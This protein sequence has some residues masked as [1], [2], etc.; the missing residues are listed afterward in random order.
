MAEPETVNTAWFHGRMAD[1][2]LSQRGLARQIGLDPGA[3]SLT[4]RGKRTMRMHEAIDLARLLGVPLA[5]L[6]V[7]SGIRQQMPSADI[8][9]TGWLDQ[10]GEVHFEPELG[11]I[12]RPHGLPS[13][14]TAVQCRTAGSDL[15]YMDGWLLFVDRPAEPPTADHLGRLCLVRMSGSVVYLAQ[16]RRGYTAGRWNLA[17]P[18]AHANDVAVDW[19]A[20]ILTIRT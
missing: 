17:G 5:E 2:K 14:V 18:V 19:S 11:Q 12:P 20:P 3:L 7:H 6:L 16:L 15:D 13:E 8:A 4:L 1:R 10:H 9:V